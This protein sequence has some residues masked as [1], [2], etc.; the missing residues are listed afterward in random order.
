MI[1]VAV[2]CLPIF[3]TGFRI[4]RWE[5]ALFLA[6]Y[7]AYTTLLVLAATRNPALE[8]FRNATLLTAPLVVIVLGGSTWT[9]VRAQRKIPTPSRANA[10]G[11]S[12]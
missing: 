5:G 4:A 10:K 7:V 11:A 3:F 12:P 9:A 6:G 2:A 8:S 1:A